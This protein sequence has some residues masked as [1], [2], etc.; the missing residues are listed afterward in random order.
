ML[1]FIVIILYLVNAK[2]ILGEEIGG[3]SNFF[4]VLDSF[5]FSLFILKI[6]KIN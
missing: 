3:E 6:L 2:V 1:I 5:S 4:F